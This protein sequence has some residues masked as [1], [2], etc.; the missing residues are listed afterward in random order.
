ME[1]PDLDRQLAGTLVG[2]DVP[3]FLASQSGSLASSMHREIASLDDVATNQLR[4]A[5]LVPPERYSEE[6]DAFNKWMEIA[7]SNSGNPIVVR[8]QVMTQL[9]V[10][11]VWLRDSVLAPAKEAVGTGTVLDAVVDFLRTGDR[12]RLRNAVA[13]G[14]WCYKPDFSGL[15]CWAKPQQRGAHER[16]EISG[17]DLERWQALS[18]GTAIAVL[19]ALTERL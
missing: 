18:R 13:H 8:A 10:A 17:D 3:T 6:L 15:E 14:H 7:H 4:R 19:L 12:R 5:L 11:F 2:A 9:Y 16:F 1:L